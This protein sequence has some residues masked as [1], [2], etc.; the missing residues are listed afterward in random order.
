V[1]E[2]K[3]WGDLDPIRTTSDREDFDWLDDYAP[4]G[5]LWPRQYGQ[6]LQIA[7]E[8]GAELSTRIGP[9]TKQV[10]INDY[11]P[12]GQ[13]FVTDYEIILSRRGWEALLAQLDR[14]QYVR[15]MVSRIVERELAAELAWLREAGHEI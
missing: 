13:M 14:Q 9:S 3:S 7:F 15:E 12:D 1:S 10:I 11:L 6:E 8:L 4:D 5:P 2:I